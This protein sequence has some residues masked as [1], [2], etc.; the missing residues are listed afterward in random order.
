VQVATFVPPGEPVA[1][2][3]E[4]IDENKQVYWPEQELHALKLFRMF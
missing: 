2:F 1:E 3:L 4:E